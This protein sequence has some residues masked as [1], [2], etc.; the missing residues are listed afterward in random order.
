MQNRRS[1]SA[2][3]FRPV[4]QFYLGARKYAGTKDFT[5]LRGRQCNWMEENVEKLRPIPATQTP[6]LIEGGCTGDFLEIRQVVSPSTVLGAWK[7]S[8]L[9]L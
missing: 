4:L 8:C 1:T 7:F 5:T 3:Q 9:R 2:S 6:G